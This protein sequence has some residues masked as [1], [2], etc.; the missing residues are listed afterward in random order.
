M[1]RRRQQEKQA[2]AKAEER[3]EGR[4]LPIGAHV[5]LLVFVVLVIDQVLYTYIHV[6]PSGYRL[7]CAD[8]VAARLG[9]LS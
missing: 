9:R 5:V 6:Y 3:C 8:P 1:S 2:R 4:N 7:S